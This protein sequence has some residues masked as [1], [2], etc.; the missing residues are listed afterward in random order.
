MRRGCLFALLA[1]PG[2]C[3]AVGAF[4]WFVALPGIRDDIR[5]GVEDGIATEVARRLPPTPGLGVAPGTYRLTEEDLL[6]GLR[7]NAEGA[8]L[9]D[10]VLRLAPEGIELDF[11]ARGQTAT[12]AGRPAA[13]DGRLLLRDMATDNAALA[14]L[15]PP[16]DLGRAIAGAV[17][18]YLAANRLRLQS[19][20]STDGAVTL[21]TVPAG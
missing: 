16:A 11:S 4:A 19:V 21:T 20:E 2:L 15:L 6:T 10:L 17:N 1:L 13:A 8:N 5:G 3:L 14:L 9:D 7:A 12:Y 18:G